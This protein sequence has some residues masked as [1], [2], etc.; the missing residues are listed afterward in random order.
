V[1]AGATEQLIAAD[2]AAAAHKEA[3]LIFKAVKGTKQAAVP[4]P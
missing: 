3:M 1:A 2:P 4:A